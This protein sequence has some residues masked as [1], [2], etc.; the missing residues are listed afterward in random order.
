MKTLS[1]QFYQIFFLSFFFQNAGYLFPES[2]LCL[3]RWHNVIREQNLKNK[4]TN[5]KQNLKNNNTN[6]EQNLKN[7]NTNVEQNLKN[8]NTNVEQNFKEQK[9]KCRTKLKKTIIQMQ[10]KT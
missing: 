7:N 1:K 3:W 2:G 9:Q 4:N 10:N 8:N 5:A 6:V